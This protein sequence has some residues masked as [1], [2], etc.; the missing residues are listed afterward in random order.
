MTQS[1]TYFDINIFMPLINNFCFIRK[2]R[3]I[4]VFD[5]SVLIPFTFIESLEV[6]LINIMAVLMISRPLWR[7]IF[8]SKGYEVIISFNDFTKKL[9][10][11]DSDHTVDV[12]IWPKLGNSN[13]FTREL[14]FYQ[15]FPEKNDFFEEWGG[16]GS[17]LNVWDQ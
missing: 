7:K 14:L 1:L 5:T 17:I 4:F 8:E 6:V 11:C 15:N 13:F 9:S 16:L 2:Y 10:S 12:V 3:Q